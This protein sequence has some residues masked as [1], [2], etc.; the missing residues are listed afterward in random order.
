MNYCFRERSKISQPAWYHEG[1][2]RIYYKRLLSFFFFLISDAGSVNI[3]RRY[4]VFYPPPG[5]GIMETLF[6]VGVNMT[7]VPSRMYIGRLSRSSKW[8]ACWFIFDEYFIIRS[9]AQISKQTWPIVFRPISITDT[10]RIIFPFISITMR[11]FRFRTY[12]LLNY[13]LIFNYG[14]SID[15]IHDVSIYQYA[16]TVDNILVK[17]FVLNLKF[18]KYTSFSIIYI[19]RYLLKPITS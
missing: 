4:R 16:Y 5:T 13:T 14:N 11:T 1:S 18:V 3:E 19:R 9:N 2:A 10:R 7:V 8:L 12:I 6:S 17:I 15:Y